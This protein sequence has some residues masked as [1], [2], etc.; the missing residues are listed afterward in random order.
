MQD[1]E[2]VQNLRLLSR[3]VVEHDSNVLGCSGVQTPEGARDYGLLKEIVK[4][5]NPSNQEST[6]KSL[7]K[8]HS[9]KRF[10]RFLEC[11]AG[12][13]GE[14]LSPLKPV[15]KDW[16]KQ[17]FLQICRYQH[18]ATR[19]SNN[20]NKNQGNITQSKEQKNT[21]DQTNKEEIGG[22]PENEFRVMIVEMIQNLGNR[23]DK[24]QKRLTRI[25]KN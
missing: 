20:N 22:L 17:L 7:E 14:S 12:M 18:K 6:H 19:N 13:I 25:Q 10:E 15:C 8:I 5:V 3:R 23:M 11:L 24:T 21:A 4:L 2:K 9:Q 1:W 16:E